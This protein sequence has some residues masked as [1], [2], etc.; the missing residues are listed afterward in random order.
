MYRLGHWRCCV[1]VRLVG[2]RRNKGRDGNHRGSLLLLPVT[3]CAHIGLGLMRVDVRL[4]GLGTLAWV[5][6]TK[7]IGDGR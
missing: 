7:E 1:G 5:V 6:E 3:Y 2:V 4:V